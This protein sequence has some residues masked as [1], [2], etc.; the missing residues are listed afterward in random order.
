MSEQQQTNG[1]GKSV[2]V[3]Q[4]RFPWVKA[5]EERYGVDQ[6]Q[7]RALIDAVFPTAKTLDSVVLALSYCRARGLD[8]FKRPIHIVPMYDKAR[9]GTVDTIWPGIGELRTTAARTGEH[10]GRDPA[11]WGPDVTKKYGDVE[12]THPEWCEVVTYR[13]VKGQRCAFHGPR[14]YW[15]ETYATRAHDS[16]EPNAM[17]KKRPRGQLEKCADAA[18]LR[19][20]FPEEIGNEY[21][22]EE[23]EG[24][25]IEGR[26]EQVQAQ[27]AAPSASRQP[28]KNKLA[29]FA[30]NGEAGE[31]AETTGSTAPEGSSSAPASPD[32]AHISA[33]IH[34]VCDALSEARSPKQRKDA[35][36]AAQAL[37]RE[38]DATDS[39]G[40]QAV[41]AALAAAEDAWSG[42]ETL[43]PEGAAGARADAAETALAPSA[44]HSQERKS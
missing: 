23:M 27:I 13:M 37:M 4:G 30:Q 39:D 43:S 24:K 38:L 3:A 15:A 42:V 20:A 28:A 14:V 8:V 10:A 6:V 2:T 7:W 17:W 31:P 44:R 1:S 40:K 32:P 29:A 12:V 11:I 16:Q 41:I 34:A 22:A 19:A 35:K 26:F 25:V 36:A 33:R 9:G 5:F 18:S 21:T